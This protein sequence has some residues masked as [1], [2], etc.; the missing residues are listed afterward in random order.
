MVGKVAAVEYDPNR[1]ANSVVALRRWRE[2]IHCL[3]AWLKGGEAVVSDIK[4]PVA[5]GNS[6]PLSSMP[7]GTEIH[8]VELRP[9]SGGQMVRRQ[10]RRPNSLRKTGILLPFVSRRAKFD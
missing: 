7:L 3:P 5:V 6:M 4:A 9:G 10:A 2:K 1:I 8:N